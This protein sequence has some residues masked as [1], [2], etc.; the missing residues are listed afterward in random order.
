MYRD[1]SIDS[2]ALSAMQANEMNNHEIIFRERNGNS[3]Y[4]KNAVHER[5][6]R[7]K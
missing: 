4:N 3:S 2:I 7:F 6:D 5:D 1:T